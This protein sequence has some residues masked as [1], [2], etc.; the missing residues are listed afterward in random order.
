M[1]HNEDVKP[2]YNYF[3][4]QSASR[5]S[6][7]YPGVAGGASSPLSGFSPSLLKDMF[8]FMSCRHCIFGDPDVITAF[9]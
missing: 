7:I 8:S 2:L 3:L 5:C 9:S 1:V 4:M 6:D